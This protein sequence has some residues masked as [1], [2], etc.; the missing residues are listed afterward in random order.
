M[1]EDG[2]EATRG[3]KCSPPKPPPSSRT[4]RRPGQHRHPRLH[5]LGMGAGRRAVAHPADDAL[6]DARQPEQVVAEIPVQVRQAVA[7]RQLAVLGHGLRDGRHAVGGQVL[8][9]GQAAALVG[10]HHPVHQEVAEVGQRVAQ[11][12]QL[13]VQHRHHPGLGGVQDHVVQAIVAMDDRGHVVGRTGGRQEGDQPVHVLD[14]TGL[15]GLVLLGPAVDLAGE[16]VA[17]LAV[18]GQA[19]G[20]VV[21]IVQ[22]RQGGDLGLVDRPALGRL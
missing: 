2:R 17:R 16:V 14:R 7:A 12:R 18:V 6:A 8:D 4:P 21:D 9:L 3:G 1:G 20:G 15:G 13:P 10:R 19:D 11:G 22:G 5:D